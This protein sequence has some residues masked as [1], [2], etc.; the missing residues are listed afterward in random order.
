MAE[1]DL[2]VEGSPQNESLARIR[3]DLLFIAALAARKTAHRG[4]SEPRES[5]ESLREYRSLHMQ[6]ETRVHLPWKYKGKLTDLTGKMD[7]SLWYGEDPTSQESNLVVVEAK[8]CAHNWFYQA[9]CYM[10]KSICV[11]S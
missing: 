11:Y 9:I 8:S 3:I 7:Y 1:Y 5:F 6:V 10:G 2:V 4:A